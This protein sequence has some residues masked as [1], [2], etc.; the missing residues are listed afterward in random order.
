MK[1]ILILLGLTL[2]TACMLHTNNKTATYDI[3]EPTNNKFHGIIKIKSDK[4][5]SCSAFVISDIAALT[6]GHCIV[7]D[8]YNKKIEIK[9]AKED[10]VFLQQEIKKLSYR[11]DAQAGFLIMKYTAQLKQLQADLQLVNTPQYN[12]DTFKIYT[13]SG[14]DTKVKAIGA[15]KYPLDDKGM[16]TR[17][18]GII[19]GDFK[20]FNKMKVKKKFD[21]EPLDNLRSC[22]YPGN[23][24][25]PVC[26]DF[27][28]VNQFNFSYAGRSMIVPGMSGGPV[29]DSDGYVVGIN[30]AVNKTFSLFCPTMGILR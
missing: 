13:I 20:A 24:E 28:A 15:F 21:I 2:L 30:E 11:K 26:I 19:K 12:V 16:I 5:S 4:G 6:S 23:A 27:K 1:K 29:I 14:V 18:Y 7:I 10:V 8:Q 25:S 9:K 17:D 3:S 22:G